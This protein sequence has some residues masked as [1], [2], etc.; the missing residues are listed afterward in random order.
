MNNKYFN[1][2]FI[3][4]LISLASFDV[5]NESADREVSLLVHKTP[6]CGCCKR[7]MEHFKEDGF[8]VYSQDHQNLNQI[9]EKYNIDV[10]YR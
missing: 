8:K 2:I 9:N 5:Q 7:W 10:S 3:I 4:L 1:K 6:T